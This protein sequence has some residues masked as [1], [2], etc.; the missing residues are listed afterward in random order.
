MFPPL[1]DLFDIFNGR[2]P[3]I[4]GY[5]VDYNS[6]I[7]ESRPNCKGGTFRSF[8]DRGIACC[9][10]CKRLLYVYTDDYGYL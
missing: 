2:P 10:R 7:N 3:Y 1:S 9:T 6:P 4:K 8:E 5:R